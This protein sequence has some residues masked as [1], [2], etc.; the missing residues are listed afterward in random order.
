MVRAETLLSA[1]PYRTVDWER[2][3]SIQLLLPPHIMLHHCRYVLLG[4]GSQIS[5]EYHDILH[6][7]NVT[8]KNLIINTCHCKPRL[9]R[10]II[11]R[12]PMLLGE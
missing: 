5:T 7:R 8:N 4:L 11:L 3:K 6:E 2:E 10:T 9:L 1:A 12:K